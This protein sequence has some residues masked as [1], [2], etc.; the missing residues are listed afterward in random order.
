M[1]YRSYK[2][3]FNKAPLR[4]VTGRGNNPKNDSVVDHVSGFWAMN[5]FS[6]RF[7]CFGVASLGAVRQ[8]VRKPEANSQEM[9][10]S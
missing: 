3:P 5:L 9:A 4:T 7:N 8:N 1:G 10:S 6:L 2:N